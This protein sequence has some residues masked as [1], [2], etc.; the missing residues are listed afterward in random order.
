MCV[1][2][3]TCIYKYIYIYVHTH[4]YHQPS[5][6]KT[7]KR[8]RRVRRDKRMKIIIKKEVEFK[9]QQ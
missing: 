2:M 7:M 9:A 3:H 8:K 5:Y 1:C 6:N 4:I